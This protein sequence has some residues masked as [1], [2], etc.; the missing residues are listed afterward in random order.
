[1]TVSFSL[2]GIECIAEAPADTPLL[3]VL[4]NDFAFKGAKYGC[5]LGQCGACCV[6]IDSQSVPSCAVKLA[7]VQGRSVETLEGLSTHG[8]LHPLQQAFLTEQAAQCG[9]CTA[10][11]IMAAKALLDVTPEPTDAE[12]K[13]AL[14]LNLCRCGT[15]PRILKAVQRA[16]KEM[17]R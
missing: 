1:M 13:Q 3:Y 12:I 11:V 4:R 17:K 7:D 5:G 8:R 2:N 10:G 15:Y 16:A 9:F 14:K 6:V